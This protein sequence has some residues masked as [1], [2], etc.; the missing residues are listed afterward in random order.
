MRF[1]YIIQLIIMLLPALQE[2]ASV[3]GGIVLALAGDNSVTLSVDSRFSSGSTGNMLLANQ[4]RPV[5]RIGSR[6]L[7]ACLGLDADIVQLMDDLRST[8]SGQIEADIEPESISRVVSDLLYTSK[9]IC[10]PVIVGIGTSGPYLCTMDGLGA[11]TT[12]SAFVAAGTSAAALLTACEAEYAPGRRADKVL[13]DANRILKNSL[14]RD[15]LSGCQIVSYT[16]CP[17]GNVFRK[18]TTIPDV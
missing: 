11:M 17:S 9:Y 15:V 5:Y 3:H 10:T 8:L 16:L 1:L 14:Q 13:E 4:Q 18:V 2:A 7:I 6:T 12:S